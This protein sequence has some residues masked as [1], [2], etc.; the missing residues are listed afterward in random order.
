MT[1]EA[2]NIKPMLAK[3]TT[4]DV[5]GVLWEIRAE[6]ID[7]RARTETLLKGMET[8]FSALTMKVDKIGDAVTAMQAHSEVTREQVSSL[9]SKAGDLEARI[10]VI[11]TNSDLMVENRKATERLLKGQTEADTTITALREK[12]ADLNQRMA[13]YAGAAAVVAAI[14]TMLANYL[15]KGTP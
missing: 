3:A 9:S 5:M 12:I 11:E 14:L 6:N 15:L 8:Q 2:A 7:A 13:Y 10:R 4:A 1:G